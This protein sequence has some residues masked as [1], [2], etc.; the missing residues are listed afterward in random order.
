MGPTA[1]SLVAAACLL[2]GFAAGVRFEE[3]N[4]E[5]RER[6]LA[7]ERRALRQT[8]T[9]LDALGELDRTLLATRSRLRRDAVRDEDLLAAVEE[10]NPDEGPRR[11]PRRPA[12]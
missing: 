4:L 12:A 6:R 9:T 8:A 5:L 7:R 2:V 1:V 3:L 10:L 11:P